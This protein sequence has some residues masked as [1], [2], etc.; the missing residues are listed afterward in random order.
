MSTFIYKAFISYSHSDAKLTKWFHRKLESYR[1]PKKL[2]GTETKTGV[3]PRRLFPIFRDR[4]DLAATTN[5]T[6]AI[7]KAVHQSEFMIV[8]CTPASAKSKLVNREIEEFKKHHGNRNI[9]CLIA[10][11]VPFSND[12]ETE[13]FSDILMRHVTPEGKP[14]GWAPEGLAADARPGSDGRKAAVSK[15]VAGLLGIELN[16]LM[17]RELHGQQRKLFWG[18]AGSLISTSVV[19]VLLYI[20]LQAQNLAEKRTEDAVDLLASLHENVFDALDADGNTEAQEVLVRRVFDHY[21]TLDLGDANVKLLGHWSASGLRLGQNLERQGRNAEAKE[22]FEKI[23]AFSIRFAS[24]YPRNHFARYR[25]QNTEFFNGYLLQR[26]GFYSDAEESFRT[27]LNISSNALVDRGLTIQ[28]KGIHIDWLTEVADS[29]QLLAALLAGPGDQLVEAETLLNKAVKNWISYISRW[30]PTDNNFKTNT[31]PYLSSLASAHLYLGR[32]LQ[33]AGRL[34]EANEQ[35]EKRYQIYEGMLE[36]APRNMGLMRRQVVS[37]LRLAEIQMAWG[38]PQIAQ[39]IVTPACKKSGEIADKNQTS[40]LWLSGKVACLNLLTKILLIQNNHDEI[41]K[42]LPALKNSIFRL[43][44]GDQERPHYRLAAYQSTLL[45]IE[46]LLWSGHSI[47]GQQLLSTLVETVDTETQ[48][49]PKTNGAMEFIARTYLLS[50]IVHQTLDADIASRHLNRVN[51]IVNS[52]PHPW[53]EARAYQAE[54]LRR[55]NN[56]KKAKEILLDLDAIG[57]NHSTFLNSISR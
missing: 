23:K 13:C 49:F 40:V 29:Q 37:Q 33:R 56:T 31:M 48:S 12:P 14:E 52:R 43:R 7:M 27:R 39:D 26:T 44:E 10:S 54:A 36:N 51:D 15:L 42:I 30:Q 25:L 3:V 35:F 55:L 45:E 19:S 57:F 28:T 6:D 22:I 16:A 24:E 1:I 21:E 46:H 5:M 9:L 11:G 47:Q 2:V 50:G 17:R 4:D 53:P 18:L 38:H 20:A 41:S 8:I 32:L 34:N